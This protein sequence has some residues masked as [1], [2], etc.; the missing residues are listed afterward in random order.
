VFVRNGTNWVQQA[1]LKASNTHAGDTFGFSVAVSGDTVVVG[2]P[3]ES[4]NA[5][6]V[7]GNQNNNSAMAAGAAYVFVRNGTIWTQQAYRKA[8]NAGAGD[9]FGL[10]VAVSGDTVVVG[11]D[12]EA[13]I[14]F[15]LHGDQ[16][17]NSAYASGAG[18]VFV[19]SGTSWDQQAYLKASNTEAD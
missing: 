18:Y 12:G 16:S 7:N 13:S 8:S 19:R 11:A 14:A 3:Y 9:C 5:L 10:S 15:G 6:G 2:A 17:S 4:S 1:Y